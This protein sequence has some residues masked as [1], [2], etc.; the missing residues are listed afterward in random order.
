MAG[1]EFLRVKVVELM[2]R[3]RGLNRMDHESVGIRPQ[4][5]PYAPSPA[6]FEAANRRLAKID[7]EV[8]RRLTD[9]KAT[10]QTAPP[11]R[12]LTD[13]ALVEREMDRARRAFGMFFEMFSPARHRLRSGAR[14]A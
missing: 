6:H 9:L 13:I 4:D 7:K 8:E 3:G 1:R 11:E 12:V 5:R 2:A 10:W 14:G